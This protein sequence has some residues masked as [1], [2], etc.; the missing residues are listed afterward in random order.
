MSAK[1]SPENLVRVSNVSIVQ[2][3]WYTSRLDWLPPMIRPAPASVVPQALGLDM[4][5]QRLMGESL[6]RGRP[7]V[8]PP[9]LEECHRA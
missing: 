6:S 3:T 4:A 7:D 9:P 1:P 2:V 5:E 8:Q